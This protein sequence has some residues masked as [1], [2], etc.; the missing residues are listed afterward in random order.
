MSRQAP[1]PEPEEQQQKRMASTTKQE[2]SHYV[3][4]AHPPGA[5]LL[6]KACNFTDPDST[7]RNAVQVGRPCLFRPLKVVFSHSWKRT[8]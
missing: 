4:T 5:V 6:S 8:S 1:P 3:V 2:A 7:V